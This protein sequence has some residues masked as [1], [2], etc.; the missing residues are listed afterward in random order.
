MPRTASW[1]SLRR[2]HRDRDRLGALLFGGDDDGRAT[3]AAS[4]RRAAAAP[5]PIELPER[6][7]QFGDIVEATDA[8]GEGRGAENQRKHQ[9]RIK[10]R[11]AAAYSKAYDG[12]AATY[13]QYAD[14]SLERLPWVIAVR[15]PAPGLT[16]GPV[17]RPRVP[18]A[19][20]AAA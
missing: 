8:K 19:R 3:A 6:L 7:G 5:R 14:E 20:G 9:A 12:A 16:I 4:R 10:E 18:A 1:W 2:R 17:E 11:T 13:R 15:A